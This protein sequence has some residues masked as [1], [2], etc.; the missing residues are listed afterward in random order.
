M[1]ELVHLPCVW[2]TVSYDGVMFCMSLSFSS[3]YVS[4][5]SVCLFIHPSVGPVIYLAIALCPALCLCVSVCLSIGLSVC[6]LVVLYPYVFVLS[7]SMFV[8]SPKRIVN[9]QIEKLKSLLPESNL[10]F[11]SGGIDFY[12][13]KSKEICKFVLSLVSQT[14]SSCER[15]HD[16]RAIGI[17]LARNEN[18]NLVTGGF[19]GVGETVGS[20]PQKTVKIGPCSC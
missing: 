8:H 18:L 7:V 5:L 20:L 1:S 4:C 10:V 14:C 16:N 19:Y 6:V 11:I 17:A 13:P 9:L 3:I 2:V 15:F 12:N